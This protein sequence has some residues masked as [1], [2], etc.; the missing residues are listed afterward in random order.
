MPALAAA[1]HD[2]VGLARN[3]PGD[4][5]DLVSLDLFDRDGLLGFAASW[6]P[7]AIVH[8][9]T[10]IPAEIN[11]RRIARDF[12]LT[13][14][15]RTAGTANLAAAANVAG[16]ARLISQSICFVY[17]PAPGL[18]R[19]DDPLW[20]D[21]IMD[22]VVP[23]VAE[24]ERVTL[25]AP[26]GGTVLRFGHLYG[27]GTAYAPGGGMSGAA[28]ARKLPILRSG[29]GESTFSFVHAADAGAAIVAAVGTR[30]HRDV[31]HRRRRARAGFG[32]AA[33]PRRGPRGQAA[34]GVAGRSGPAAR[35]SIRGRVHDRAPGSKQRSRQGRARLEPVDR[36]VARGLPPG[37]ILRLRGHCRLATITDPGR[38]AQLVEQE[39]LNLKVAGSNPA[40]PIPEPVVK[41]AQ[42]VSFPRRPATPSVPSTLIR[43]RAS[44]SSPGRSKPGSTVTALE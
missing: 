41:P 16:G 38:L 10:A 21:P 15:L 9:A 27:P 42:P 32:V 34:A 11:P 5:D 31:Q 8:L 17:R 4:R 24:L 37:L 18:A 20:H 12:E 26:G 29:K 3:T 35:R 7:E 1:G 23:A 30:A 33:R 36:L 2:V 19:E 25:A 22:P 44:G 43:G 13:N 40:S 6:K 28:A 39:T 14:R